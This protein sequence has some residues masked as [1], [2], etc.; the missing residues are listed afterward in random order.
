MSETQATVES[1]IN[2][3]RPS[4]LESEGRANLLK[5]LVPCLRLGLEKNA[6]ADLREIVGVYDAIQLHCDGSETGFD[7]VA[8]RSALGDARALDARA[9]VDQSRERVTKS[10]ENKWGKL[11][12]AEKWSKLAEAIRTWKRPASEAESAAI[13]DCPIGSTEV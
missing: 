10:A 3:I 4:L 1:K 6:V 13:E 11:T 8:L 5:R 9:L 7:Q 12:E 2:P